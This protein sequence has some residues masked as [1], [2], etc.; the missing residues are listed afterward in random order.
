MGTLTFSVEVAA[1]ASVIWDIWSELEASPRWDTDVVSCRLDGAFAPGTQGL[2][3]L[4]NGLRMP[5]TLEAMEAGRS[6]RNSA[7]LPGA[8][9]RFDHVV[10][11]MTPTICR[12][13][14]QGDV[15]AIRPWLWR[16]LLKTLLRPA[17]A[18]ALNNLARLAEQQARAARADELHNH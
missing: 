18:N 11:A 8:T 1:P 13:T 2:C 3:K 15:S 10:E 14:H 5:I 16:T 6:W 4:K 12:V 7:R 17:L 9:L